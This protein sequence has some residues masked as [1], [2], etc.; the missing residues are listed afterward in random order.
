MYR[1]NDIRGP[2][3][4]RF[5]IMVSNSP[6]KDCQQDDIRVPN[7]A[8][9]AAHPGRSVDDYALGGWNMEERPSIQSS[10]TTL[11]SGQPLWTAL[12]SMR[13]I[14]NVTLGS[15]WIVAR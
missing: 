12:N 11:L 7:D 4:A 9:V 1:Q 5:D 6:F 13:V 8:S 14:N 2:I 3:Y 10:S 15:G